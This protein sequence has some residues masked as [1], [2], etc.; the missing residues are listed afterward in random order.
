M[1]MM[2]QQ[3]QLCHTCSMSVAVASS[4]RVLLC[5]APSVAVQANLGLSA[6][7][8]GC[9]T[10]SNGPASSAPLL[11]HTLPSTLVMVVLLGRK[12]AAS[13]T[14]T[15]P[16]PG[17]QSHRYR[18]VSMSTSGGSCRHWHVVLFVTSPDRRTV[19][20]QL[21]Q[22]HQTQDFPW[23]T[24]QCFGG[25]SSLISIHPPAA[26]LLSLTWIVRVCGRHSPLHPHPGATW[27][28]WNVLMFSAWPCCCCWACARPC[29]PLCCGWPNVC[30]SWRCLEDGELEVQ[31]CAVIREF[32]LSSQHQ[33][34]SK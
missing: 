1:R 12:R 22:P 28:P 32:A 16:S 27:H 18:Q 13:T 10:P 29:R 31:Q 25:A 33:W 23:P 26:G 7:L 9:A 15:K 2:H 5:A 8:S 19:L 34:Q 11:D 24:G 4:N 17:A 30:F 6:S 21:H 14:A 3:P 20:E